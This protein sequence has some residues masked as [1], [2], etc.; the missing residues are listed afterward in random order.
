MSGGLERPAQCVRAV[1]PNKISLLRTGVGVPHAP[2]PAM[3]S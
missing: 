3:D 2:A 1:L